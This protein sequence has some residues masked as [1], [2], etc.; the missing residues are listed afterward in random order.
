MSTTNRRN[1][2]RLLTTAQAAAHLSVSRRKLEGWVKSGFVPVV[3]L[4]GT[5]RRFDIVALD[6]IIDDS[7]RGGE[8]R[9]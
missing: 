6:Q 8:N 5:V 9:R 4:D 7:A 1:H 3:R 2:R